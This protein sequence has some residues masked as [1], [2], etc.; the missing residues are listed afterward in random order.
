MC[1][2]R[3]EDGKVEEGRGRKGEREKRRRKKVARE[4]KKDDDSV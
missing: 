3:R 4:E 2:R 1:E